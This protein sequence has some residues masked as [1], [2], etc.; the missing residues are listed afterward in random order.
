MFPG[1]AGLPTNN[2]TYIFFPVIIK[3]SNCADLSRK[4]KLSINFRDSFSRLAI[5]D[6]IRS[7][8]LF[9]FFFNDETRFIDRVAII[10]HD[11]LR[12]AFLCDIVDGYLLTNDG[13]SFVRIV[14]CNLHSVDFFFFFCRTELWMGQAS[15]S[16]LVNIRRLKNDG[17]YFT[18]K[19]A[20]TTFPL[21][22]DWLVVR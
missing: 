17:P 4:I 20:Y 12:Y 5:V 2:E 3:Q 16:T 1:D 18:R 9:S 6:L 14:R 10:P 22:D 7:F 19:T 8:F 15:F 11:R 13:P 21:T